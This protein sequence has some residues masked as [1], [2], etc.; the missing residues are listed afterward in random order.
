MR[1]CETCLNLMHPQYSPVFLF[2]CVHCNITAEPRPEDTLISSSVGGGGGG[3]RDQSQ[4]DESS[5]ALAP[6]D[7][8]AYRVPHE[9]PACKRPYLSQ[10]CIA[11]AMRV[12][13][14]CVCGFSS[15]SATA[16]AED[17]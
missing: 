3:V 15:S 1:F 7:R 8:A 11:A 12:V 16:V 2:R 17:L 4:D 5:V 10:V 9:C 13:R 6:F 14:V